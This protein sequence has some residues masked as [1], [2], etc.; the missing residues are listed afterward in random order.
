MNKMGRI[1][2]LVLAIAIV[3]SC[4]FSVLAENIDGT[5]SSSTSSIVSSIV[6]KEKITNFSMKT[7]EVTYASRASRPSVIVKDSK[8]NVISSE[9]YTLSYSSNSKPGKAKVKVTMKGNYEGS[10][11]LTFIIKPKKASK[12]NLSSIQQKQFRVTVGEDLT[13]SGYQISYS[14]SKEFKNAKTVNMGKTTGVMKTIKNVKNKTYYVRVRN[15][16]TIDG[17]KVYGA[18]SSKASIKVKSS[19]PA[20]DIPTEMLES[21]VMDSMKYVGYKVDK[22]AKMGTLLLDRASGPRTPMSVRSGIKYGGGPSGQETVKDKST[23]TGKAPNLKKFRS[24]GMC[25]ASFVSYYYLN[26]LP[27]IAGVDT[28]Y[29]KKAVK[30]SGMNSQSAATWEYVAKKLVKSGNAKVVDKVKSGQRLSAA[31]LE[32]LEIGDLLTFSC[33]NLGVSC[34]H[35]AVY[36]GTYGGDHFVAHVGSD[37]GP[38]FQ[39]LERFENVVHQIDGCAYSVVYRFKDLPNSKYDYS[40]KLSKTKVKY[41]G[42]AQTPKVTAYDAAGN[43]ISSKNYTV[44]YKNNT[45]VGTATAKIVFKGK[46]RGTKTLKFKITQK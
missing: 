14:T 11:T 3:I 45:K 31:H 46:Y 30:K 13:A 43:K 25:C 41:N 24:Q 20:A 39:T 2:P 7:N 26:Y 21:Y 28:D 32:K 44:H 5:V 15:Y 6:S 34:G 35:V 23:P 37:E 33:P 27:N 9:N 29:I 16:K 22:H 38:V 17:K 36:A 40:A 12:P 42:K 4:S 1:I 18:W 8:G 10:K 19:S